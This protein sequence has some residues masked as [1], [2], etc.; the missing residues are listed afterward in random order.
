VVAL[1]TV[2]MLR[3]AE[4]ADAISEAELAEW[5]STRLRAERGAADDVERSEEFRR[6]LRRLHRAAG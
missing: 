4:A 5:L 6:E 3:L 2:A 1:F